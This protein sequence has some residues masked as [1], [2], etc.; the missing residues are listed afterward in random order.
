MNLLTQINQQT[1]VIFNPNIYQKNILKGNSK[2][3]Y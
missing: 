2:A 1:D 3:N